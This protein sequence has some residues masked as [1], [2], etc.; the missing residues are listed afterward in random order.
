MPRKSKPFWQ[1]SAFVVAAVD[2]D[3]PFL[4]QV[5]LHFLGGGFNLDAAHDSQR[6]SPS[7]AKK[8]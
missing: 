6:G 5:I 3:A 7:P 8:T 1:W 2:L 4:S